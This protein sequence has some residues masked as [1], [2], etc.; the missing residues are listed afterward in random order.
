MGS[1]SVESKKAKRKAQKRRKRLT[2][3]QAS[4][5]SDGD[6]STSSE[7]V[8]IRMEPSDVPT[9]RRS[10]LLLL[11]HLVK[12]QIYHLCGDRSMPSTI[13]A[14]VFENDE[15]WDQ[16]IKKELREYEGY[17]DVHPSIL[18]D[19]AWLVEVFVDGTGP[20]KGS[21]GV[22]L[23]DYIGRLH[24][25]DEKGVRICRLLRDRIETLEDVIKYSKVQM[26]KLH[27]ENKRKVEQVRFFWRS[28]MFE[29]NTRGGQMVMSAMISI[30]ND[31]YGFYF[32]EL[33][34]LRI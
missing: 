21:A 28:K 9:L 15:F 20:H 10:H 12:Y 22:A 4:L 11:T 31:F 13:D 32:I 18:T 2:Y 3:R 17:R 27:R 6:L 14:L 34:S 30:A 19:A 16:K 24:K 26:M 33:I 25:R 29:G 7:D 23:E 5:S 1:H 8:D